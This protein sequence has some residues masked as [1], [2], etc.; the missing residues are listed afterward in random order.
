MGQ[1]GSQFERDMCRLF[2][3]WVSGGE[4]EDLF[5]RTSQSGGRATA[6][7]R[8]GAALKSK[9]FYGDMS[10]EDADHPTAKLFAD[11]V[12]VEFKRGYN[13]ASIQDI[14]DLP[15][16]AATRTMEYFLEQAARD[17]EASDRLWMLVWK[18]DSRDPIVVL[19][20]NFSA[21]LLG[22]TGGKFWNN[23]GQLLVDGPV[24]TWRLGDRQYNAMSLE[25]LFKAIIVN[26]VAYDTWR[27]KTTAGTPAN[28]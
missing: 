23:H 27:T 13:R 19:P 5:W 15:A 12:S 11:N 10:L 24:V 22:R 16:R 28:H 6:C 9:G 4:R 8:R 14:I 1:K 26:G 2:S 18:R 17:A 25:T 21:S 3:R 20:P 7:S